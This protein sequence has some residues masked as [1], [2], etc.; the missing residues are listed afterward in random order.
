MIGKIII[1]F[2]REAKKPPKEVK[3]TPEQQEQYDKH[4]D[5][6]SDRGGMSHQQIHREVIKKIGLTPP[7]K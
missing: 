7:P 6:L 3:L 2:L 4:Y 1:D 5:R